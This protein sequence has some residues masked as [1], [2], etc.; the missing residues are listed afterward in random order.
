MESLRRLVGPIRIRALLLG[1][2]CCGKWAWMLLGWISSILAS[3]VGASQPEVSGST[4]GRPD[5]IVISLDTTRADHL[6]LYGYPLATSPSLD[7]FAAKAV[8]FESARTVVPLTGPSHASLFTSLYPHQHGAFRNGI[9]LRKDVATLARIL[10]ARG[11]DCAAFLSG[12][13]LKSKLCGLQE[14]FRIYDEAFTQRYKLLNRERPAEDVTKAVGAFLDSG[15][16]SRPL[17]LFVHYFDPHDPYRQHEGFRESLR[18]RA[19]ALGMILPDK[20]CD[21]DNEISYMDHYLGE[22]L[23][24]MERRGLLDH[25]ILWIVGDHGESLGEHGYW[26]HGRRVY[27]PNLRIPMVLYAPAWFRTPARISQPVTTL[28]VMPTVLGLLSEH[29]EGI[30]ME[31]RDLSGFLARGEPL[32]EGRLYF[33]TFK[34]TLRSLTKVVAPEVPP[35]PSFLG[36]LQGNLKYILGNGL[37]SVEIYDLSSDKIEAENLASKGTHPFSPSEILS[38]YEQGRSRQ[39]V[40]VELAPEDLEGLKSLGYIN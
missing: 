30:P 7:R 32:P 14:G 13:T 16:Y 9:P 8:V 4:G 33:E 28:D 5:V 18:A 22:L 6:S 34:G 24:H 17:F 2:R 38:W 10:S 12:W 39:P 20:V 21:Y 25:A 3:S 26:G 37:K 29:L 1:I 15:R 19:A 23:L 11:Y 27:E 40:S 31:G 35:L 36:Y